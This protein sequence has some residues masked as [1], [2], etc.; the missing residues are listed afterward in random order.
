MVN[1]FASALQNEAVLAML[2]PFVDVKTMGG[3]PG[4]PGRGTPSCPGAFPGCHGGEPTTVPSA[5]RFW[6]ESSMRGNVDGS[7]SGSNFVQM[8]C[9]TSGDFGATVTVVN[10]APRRWRFVEHLDL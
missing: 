8:S 1:P 7:S 9:S 6:A 4:V 5:L 2:Q 3:A 10:E